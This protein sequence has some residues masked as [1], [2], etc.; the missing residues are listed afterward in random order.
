MT[1]IFRAG[2]SNRRKK[3][4]RFRHFNGLL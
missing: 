2:K 1:E 4:D 3:P